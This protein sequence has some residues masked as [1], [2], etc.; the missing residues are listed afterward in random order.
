MKELLKTLCALNGVSGDEDQVRAFLAE[1]AR[2]WAQS[3]KMCIRDSHH[4]GVADDGG[5]HHLHRRAPAQP[6]RARAL[7]AGRVVHIGHVHRH[8]V[9]P[10]SYTHLDVYKRQVP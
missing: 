5:V 9:V 7:R 4:G 1:R 2:P 6:G 10:V 3:M 8:G